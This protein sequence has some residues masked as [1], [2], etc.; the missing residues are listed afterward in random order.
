M[1]GW[2]VN[3]NGELVISYNGGR[4]DDTIAASHFE[5]GRAVRGEIREFVLV[6][7]EFVNP[8]AHYYYPDEYEEDSD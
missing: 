1:K 7:A 6:N 2:N 3:N 8:G 4:P 5:D